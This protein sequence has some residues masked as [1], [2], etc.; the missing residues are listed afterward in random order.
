MRGND[1]TG[2]LVRGSACDAKESPLICSLFADALSQVANHAERSPS[3]L[4]FQLAKRSLNPCCDCIGLLQRLQRRLPDP[5]P[6]ESER[7]LY[8]VV[9]HGHGHMVMVV[10][11]ISRPTRTGPSVDQRFV[12]LDFPVSLFIARNVLLERAQQALRVPRRR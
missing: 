9:G 1:E 5:Q 3:E 2:G 11:V 12:Q 8:M 4:I 7:L 10:V 6:L